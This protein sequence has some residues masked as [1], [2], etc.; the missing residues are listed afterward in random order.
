VHQNRW[1]TRAEAQSAVFEYIELFY[2]R[3]RLHSALSYLSP[4]QFESRH[5][6]TMAA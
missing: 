1:R 4:H 2:N 6:E 5:H 3:R